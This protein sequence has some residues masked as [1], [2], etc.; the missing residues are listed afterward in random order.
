MRTRKAYFKN[1]IEV[2]RPQSISVDNISYLNPSDDILQKIGYEIKHIGIAPAIPYE[3]TYEEKVVEL[4]R[5]KYSVDDELAILRQ[6]DSKPDEFIEY[7]EFCELCKQKA[8]ES[9]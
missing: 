5:T 1:G 4:I 6:R 7:N 8:K 2:K 3:P 9:I